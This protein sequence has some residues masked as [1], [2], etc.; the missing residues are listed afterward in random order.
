MHMS[1]NYAS[2]LVVKYGGGAMSEEPHESPDPVLLEIAALRRE[3][4]VV[5]VHGGGPEIDAALARV[6]VQTPRIDG[7][8]V[9]D[10]ATLEVTEAVLCA[11][12]N[13]R[14]V[15]A[16]LGLGMPAVGISGEDGAMLVARRATAANGR[17]LGYV[18]SVEKIDARLVL[19]LL[20]AAFLPIVAPL[21]IARD[22][23]HAYNVNADL[24]A[25]AI[26]GALGAAA[27]VVITNVS[28]VRR[29]AEDPASGIDRLTP[30]EAL[31]FAAGDACRSSMKPKVAAAAYA[32]NAGAAASYICAGK[33]NAIE[34]ALRGDATVIARA[35][36]K[37]RARP[38]LSSL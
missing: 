31:R 10:A 23:R 24:A 9:T 8:R 3:R 13:K 19:A 11:T 36:A 6:G 12:I 14:L 20:E 15:R 1:H 22:A 30:E 17:D 35:P 37:N 21:A 5:L 26:A 38:C 25:A 4:H 16:A 2:T 28:R 27:F 34:S 33:P 29:D 18:G 7:L 32:V